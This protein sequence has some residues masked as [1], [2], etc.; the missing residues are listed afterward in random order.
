M[1]GHRGFLF[2]VLLFS[3]L[4]LAPTPVL[5]YVGPGPGL[6]FGSQFKLLL[7][8]VVAAVGLVLLWPL[9]AVLRYF[10]GDNEKAD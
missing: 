1:R 5:A 4:L 6:A 3:H 9:C 8:W 2:L 7:L 10:V